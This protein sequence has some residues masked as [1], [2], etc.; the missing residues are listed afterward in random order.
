VNHRDGVERSIEALA[1]EQFGVVGRDQVLERG[2]T[3]RMIERRLASGAWLPLLRGVYR[4]AAAPSS[5]RQRAMATVLWSAPDGPLS[6]LTADA[7]RRNRL[8]ALGRTVIEVTPA[9]LR[10]PDDLVALVAT[11]LAA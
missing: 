7:E 5:K 2:G 4:L 11:A 8:R 1:A 3:R 10:H 9:T 6:H